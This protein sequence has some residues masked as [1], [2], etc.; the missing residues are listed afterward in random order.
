M[1][2][3]RQKTQRYSRGR[4]VSSSAKTC[5]RE[6]CGKAINL[7]DPKVKVEEEA[8]KRFPTTST[9][10]QPKK[11]LSQDVTAEDVRL[12]F[13]R[14]LTEAARRKASEASVLEAQKKTVVQQLCPYF[15]ADNPTAQSAE[16]FGCEH[17]RRQ[18]P[19]W[20]PRRTVRTYFRTAA[21][22]PRSLL[23]DVRAELYAL[24]SGTDA[25]FARDRS[26]GGQTFLK[27]ELD[28]PHGLTGWKVTGWTSRKTRRVSL[29]YLYIQELV[30]SGWVKL[31][32]ES[33]A[34]L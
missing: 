9:L 22:K 11:Q 17:V 24:G 30:A 14:M 18:R 16:H 32:K 19:G 28:S 8:S 27:G 12:N 2:D 34:N 7:S 26:F 13:R 15:V 3:P 20:L 31:D 25:L 6:T 33:S 21:R 10:P 23:V 4:T 29:R 1:D 5:W